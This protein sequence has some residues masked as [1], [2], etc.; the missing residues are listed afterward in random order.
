MWYE[1]GVLSWET[2]NPYRGF[3]A[4]ISPGRQM[5]EQCL[6]FSLTTN[7]PIHY[8]WPAFHSTL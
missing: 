6:K 3:V 2:E 4:C 7:F 8:H 5:L 1:Q